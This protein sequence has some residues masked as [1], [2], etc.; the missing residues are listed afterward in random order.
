MKRKPNLAI[1]RVPDDE[2]GL[3]T[4]IQ[5]AIKENGTISS[6][7][8]LFGIDDPNDSYNEM[9]FDHIVLAEEVDGGSIDLARFQIADKDKR[10][11]VFAIDSVELAVIIHSLLKEYD[12]LDT[13]EQSIQ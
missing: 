12:A 3:K 5:I 1:F 8:R 10:A 13:P 9:D 7:G 11:L 6:E 4:F 2:D